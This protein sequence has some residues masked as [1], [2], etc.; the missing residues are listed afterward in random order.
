MSLLNSFPFTMAP[1]LTEVAGGIVLAG[2][3]LAVHFHLQNRRR[4]PAGLPY[5]PGPKGYPIIG[6]LLDI[7]KIYIYKRFREMSKELGSDI[8]HL[9]VFGFHLVVLN[10]K[11]V[12][13]DLMDKR[14]SIYS[15]RPRMPMMCEL[16]G[17]DWSLGFTPYNEWWKN[18]RKLFHKHFQPS[19]V[20]Q[21]RPKKTKAVHDFLKR[22]ADTPDQFHNHMQLLAGSVILDIAYG[23]DIRSHDDIY[24][25]RAEECLRI[26]DKA[27]NPGSFLVDII[28]A[29][30][31]V[32]DWFPGADFKR[33]A[34]EWK[35]IADRFG[36]VP[37]EFVKSS[38][39]DG[40]AAPSFSSI[41]LRD[42]NEKD[43]RAYQEE[44]I[45]G[46]GATMYTA[47]ADTTVSVILTF[48]LGM[49]MNPEAQR[50]AQE[51]I[52][53]VIGP[54]RLPTYE[55]EAK[56]PYL[57]A[58]SKEVFRW[59]QVAPFAIPH[60]LMA[61]DVYN[62][63]FIPKDS[64]VLGNAWAIL[65]DEKLFPDPF[66]FDPGR[67]LDPNADPRIVSAVDYAF[68]FGRRVCPG[69]WMAHSFTWIIIANT[70]AAFS[71]KR[72]VDANGNEVPPAGTM[73][74]GIMGCVFV[75]DICLHSC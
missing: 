12:A 21:F 68:G 24:L 64:I 28:P 1:S 25:Q 7:P 48:F 14:S 53:R 51:E 16:M 35:A 70:L 37:F 9:Q 72:V 17:F 46:L 15:D 4:N 59:Q 58:L 44:L 63:Y 66:K 43:N 56:L 69:R 10:T 22:L 32:P 33:K 38:M 30:K 49:L 45:K 52:D 55:D 73:S 57:G 47:G 18:S 39:A 34:K 42:I 61:D 75:L 62:G 71:I 26:I 50:L 29:L 54:D 13:D 5:P 40:T 20:P 6:N 23:L 11:E 67:F 65:H 60:R 19:A 74:G 8:I 2:A 41:A 36:T 27:G 3:L 31:Y